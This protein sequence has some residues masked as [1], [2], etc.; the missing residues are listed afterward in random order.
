[1]PI[2]DDLTKV[3]ANLPTE[4]PDAQEL[5]R[6]QRFLTDMKE[7][8]VAKTRDYDLPRP[9]TIGRSATEALR[10]A[11]SSAPAGGGRFSF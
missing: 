1:M 9:D 8:G 7:A 11:T 3:L 6:L 2:V 5:M 4:M 10:K